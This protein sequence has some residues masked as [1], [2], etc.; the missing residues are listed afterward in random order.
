MARDP[1]APVAMVIAPPDEVVLD[2]ELAL[3]TAQQFVRFFQGAQHLQRLVILLTGREQIIHEL[4]RRR[5]LAEGYLRQ[6][7]EQTQAATH[8]YDEAQLGLMMQTAD[9]T[10]RQAQ[11][12]QEALDAQGL[13]D[14][15]SQ[16]CAAQEERLEALRNEA[17]Q[18]QRAA[19]HR[20]QDATAR[21]LAERQV[22]MH[23]VEADH[24]TRL[25]RLQASSAAEEQRSAKLKQDIADLRQ[26][27]VASVA[28]EAEEQ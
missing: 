19:E 23:A 3:T 18:R 21:L 1:V 6:V 17:A 4:D 13:L 14:T 28:D 8:L 16:E 27:I 9:H 7:E 5:L 2:Y 25:E 24:L 20:L 22:Q 26:R 10:A 11:M 15:L 12:G